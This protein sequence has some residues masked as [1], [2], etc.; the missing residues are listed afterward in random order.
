QTN[1][2]PGTSNGI[3][4]PGST[5]GQATA[6]SV[7]PSSISAVPLSRAQGSTG[8]NFGE[9]A[10]GTISGRV[11]VDTNN[12]GVPDG[13]ELGIAGVTIVL[14]GTDELG[15]A[16]NE[17]TVTDA[18]G[19]YRFV[20]LRPGIYRL[21]EPAQPFGTTNGITTPG[22]SGGTATA[23]SEL[24]SVISA[25]ALAAG[26]NS[27]NNNF[28]ERPATP[29]LVVSKT[30]SSTLFVEGGRYEYQIAVRNAGVDSSQGE[31]V[32]YDVLP[33]TPVP[34][35]FEIEGVPT[36]TGWTCSV[37]A[38]VFL[39]CRSSAV[40]APNAINPNRI[41]VRVKVGV[42]ASSF[43]P[44]RNAVL[45]RGGAEPAESDPFGDPLR[46]V[47]Q[48]DLRTIVRE[49]P[50]CP[51]QANPPV[52]N[53]CIVET[54]VE[55]PVALGGRVWLDGGLT[56]LGR[57]IYDPGLDKDFPDWIVE[58]LDPTLP[59]GNNIVATVRTG[60]DGRYLVENLMPGRAY[61]IQ[62]RDSEGRAIFAGPVNGERRV[63]QACGSS[64]TGSE[65]GNRQSALDIVMPPGTFPNQVTCA[66]QSLPIEPNGVVYDSTTRLPVRG[67]IVTL[68]PEGACAGYDPQRH[69]IAY[70]GYGQYDA[71]G[72]PRMAVG[73]D[74]FYKFLLSA[75]APRSCLF[76]LGVA[77]P[78]GYQS[79]STRIPAA[80]TLQ[81]PVGV[82]SI[83]YVQP[84]PTPPTGNQS[85]TYH[86]VLLGG[87]G[88]FEVFNN[89]IPLDPNAAPMIS[90][91][92][93]GDRQVGEIGDSVLYTISVSQWAGPPLSGLQVVDRLP[94]GFRYIRGTFQLGT[95]VLPDPQGGEGSVITFNLPNL[96]AGGTLQFTYRVRIGVGAAEGDGINRAQARSG[97][98]TSNV[99]QYR[100]RVTGGVFTKDACVIGKI[101]VDCNNNHV[102][103]K[104]ELG[105][106]GVRLYFEDGTFLVSDIEGKYSYCGLKPQTHVL[107]V[108]NTTLPIGSRLTTTSNRNVGDAGSLFV[109][110]KAGELHRADFAEGSCSN[111][112]LEQVK[113]RRAKGGSATPEN[114]RAG[115]TVLKFES[116]SMANPKQATD[117]AN[118]PAVR[119]QVN[120]GEG[121]SP[122]PAEKPPPVDSSR[123]RDGK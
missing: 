118:Q 76:R 105:I 50:T 17:T 43:S 35:R 62:F 49:A 42:G 10:R 4:T 109:D 34:Q 93:I 1:Q 74:G 83:F 77:P 6:V 114:E 2:P 28:G 22:S 106:P 82:G 3:T 48:Q 97:Q 108:D 66:E 69:V 59:A 20:N 55:F 57:R 60:T 72:N 21:T 67:A 90:I 25:I 81:T 120:A 39:T 14:S 112:V 36:G 38:L 94:A 33:L 24:P 7:L 107:K 23:L 63:R 19:N 110:L 40:I 37:D 58:V 104:D 54:R 18:L 61:R 86:F 31:Y 95:T 70:E 27:I 116:K 117:S 80:P 85:I 123:G 91:S 101:F 32:V 103:D 26:Q 52:H 65:L 53:A 68:K 41:T 13:G 44:L 75:D 115:G 46:V 111:P 102:Q 9:L 92:K 51:A 12:N 79:P 119:S 98:T 87:S 71:A 88:H 78:G 11:Y 89:H 8:N 47:T 15:N 122:P 113:A 84:Q 30:V 64:E 73:P 56:S 5:G 121:S 45:V 99:A 100:I 16:V 96:T 29:D